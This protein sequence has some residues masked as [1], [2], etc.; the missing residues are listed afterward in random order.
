MFERH[1][2]S[3]HPTPPASGSTS[4]VG[5]GADEQEL[6]TAISAAIV[7]LDASPYGR[8]PAMATTYLD[9]N[10]VFCLLESISA[11]EQDAHISGARAEVIDRTD[12]S[13]TA[14]KADFTGAVERLTH[15]RVRA[16]KDSQT[17][18]GAACL[19]FLLDSADPTLVGHGRGSPA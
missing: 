19:L 3:P 16:F 12:G 5:V 18:S 6:A 7:E 10:I 15:R 14:A 17:K 4:Q 2:H 1:P 13:R 11:E 9:E 8:P